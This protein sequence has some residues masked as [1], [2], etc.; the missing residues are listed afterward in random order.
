MTKGRNNLAL[1]PMTENRQTAWIDVIER[2]K[3]VELLRN[4]VYNPARLQTHGRDDHHSI[5]VDLW[6]TLL[7]RGAGWGEA[8][9][10]NTVR[11]TDLNFTCNV[12]NVIINF[13]FFLHFRTRL[14]ITIL[15]EPICIP[16]ISL[17]R[18]LQRAP[19]TLVSCT[20]AY[21]GTGGAPSFSYTLIT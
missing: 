7:R 17:G 18:H 20:I 2:I 6:S 12:V 1:A 16:S 9:L 15:M 19:A 14:D 8:D 5:K 4:R 11:P 10:E 21:E 3:K 13:L